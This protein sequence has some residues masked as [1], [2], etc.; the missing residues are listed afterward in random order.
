[1][2]R[3]VVASTLLHPASSKVNVWFGR[4]ALEDGASSKISE[5]WEVVGLRF[6][7]IDKRAAGV[8]TPTGHQLVPLPM[9]VRRTRTFPRL[10]NAT[11]LAPL[12]STSP[13]IV[14]DK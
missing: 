1:M 12:L 2:M 9:K 7:V 11:R 4:E 10:A 3:C 8:R 6:V 14:Q 13:R 5:W